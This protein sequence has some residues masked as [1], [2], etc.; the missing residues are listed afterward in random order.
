MKLNIEIKN[1]GQIKRA[2][3]K[4]RPITVLTGPNGTGKS[5]FTKSLYSILNVINTN[6]YHIDL[7]RNIHNCNKYFSDYIRVLSHS[8]KNDYNKIEE[9]TLRLENLEHELHKAALGLDLTEYIS[10]SKS[11]V[12]EVE[13]LLSDFNQYIDSLSQTKTKKKSILVISNKIKKALIEL[14][15]RLTDR[16]TFYSISLGENFSNELKENFQVSNLSELISFGEKKTTIKIDDIAT[17]EF[18]K[19][20]QFNIKHHFINKISSLSRVVFFESPAYW[21]VRDALIL[22]KN[23]TEFPY[24]LR[25][26]SNNQLSGVPKYFYDLN[27]ALKINTKIKSTININ[28][29]TK[30]IENSLGG[31]FIFSGDELRFKDFKSKKEISTNLISFGMTNLGMIHALLKKEVITSGSFVFIDEPETNLHP[32]WQVLLMDVLIELANMDINIVIATHSVDMLKALEVGLKDKK[33]E[34]AQDFMAIHYLDTDGQLLD[35]ESKLP[36][37]QL[38]EAR[39]ELTSPYE[40][41]F[42]KGWS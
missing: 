3:F 34:Q 23:K 16:N 18:E 8:G 6:V 4:V 25:K 40:S 17:I 19:T 33:K 20:V 12:N 37:K 26:E 9:F 13:Q 14:K 1:L 36:M 38:I 2:K 22:A 7:N 11:K 39:L 42:F 27:D 30:K 21:K 35:F 29:L 24:F 32:K 31:E 10:Y 41:L 28:A 15:N 5:F